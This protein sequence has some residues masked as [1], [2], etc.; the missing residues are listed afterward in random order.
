MYNDKEKLWDI[1]FM[2]F[3]VAPVIPSL[4][5]LPIHGER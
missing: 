1:L 3:G 4:V 5:L 2:I